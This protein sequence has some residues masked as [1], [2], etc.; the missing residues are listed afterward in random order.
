MPNPLD[1]LRKSAGNPAWLRAKIAER[2]IRFPEDTPDM[3]RLSEWLAEKEARTG[4]IDP[5]TSF[6]L[7]R[8]VE[9]HPVR[10]LQEGEQMR[11]PGFAERG[12]VNWNELQREAKQKF[13][14]GKDTSRSVFDDP[15]TIYPVKPED[16]PERL[17]TE[18]AN[19]MLPLGGLGRLVGRVAKVAAPAI[20]VA[21]MAA[22]DDA[23]AGF[24]GDLLKKFGFI[25]DDSGKISKFGNKQ[26]PLS[27]TP[28]SNRVW[29]GEN[30]I[31]QGELSD[32]IKGLHQRGIFVDT[33][34][35]E[36]SPSGFKVLKE[37]SGGPVR[38]S[39]N[40]LGD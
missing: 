28:F 33:V 39:W 8:N 23:E 5:E 17:V 37:S 13:P 35:P 24:K 32:L 4:A 18:A 31:P 34:S 30:N 3:R 10:E 15:E 40:I 6:I 22:S 12:S 27:E 11:L 26:S 7:Q 9:R 29:L 21:A 19:W 14:R 1:I 16:I 36:I 25:I 20:P 2:S 38:A